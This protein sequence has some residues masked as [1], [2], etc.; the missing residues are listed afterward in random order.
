MF[1]FKLRAFRVLIFLINNDKV[2]SFHRY[3][4]YC[5]RRLPYKRLS[6]PCDR[7]R[8]R[9]TPVTKRR[10]SRKEKSNWPQRHTSAGHQNFPRKVTRNETRQLCLALLSNFRRSNI[11]CIG[12]HLLAVSFLLRYVVLLTVCI[13]DC[14]VSRSECAAPNGNEKC[15][16]P[17]F[18]FMFIE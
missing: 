14:T 1:Q 4:L 16:S 5:C 6:F 7:K 18:P 8:K 17:R 15:C 3:F 11:I 13:V 10:S 2:V 12:E 9:S